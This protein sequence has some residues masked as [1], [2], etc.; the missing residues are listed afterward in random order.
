MDPKELR[1]LM[2]AYSEVYSPKENIEEGLRSAVKRLL[3][4]GKK[5]TEAPKPQSRGDQLRARYN[6]GPEGSDTSAKRK[7]LDRAK[8]NAERAQNQVDMGNASQSY[9]SNA[10]DAHNKYLKAGYSKYGADTPY[11]GRGSKARKRAAALNAEDFEFIVNAL[12]EEGYDLSSYTWDEMYDIC[13]DENR[14][15]SRMEK[16]PSAPAKVGKATHSTKD[17]VPSKEPTPEEK[18]KARKA[19]GLGEAVKGAS[20]HDTEMRKASSAERRAGDK[21]LSPAKGRDNANKMQRDIN[22]F[23]KLTKK[24]KNV[25]GLVSN[26]EVDLF[27]TVLEFLQVEGYAETLEEA[28]WLM[29]NVID[30]E[31]IAII[32]DEAEGSYG[33]TPKATAAYGA[34]ANRR[35]NTPASEYPKRGAKKVAVQ[36]AERHMSRSENPDAGNRGKQSTKPHWTSGSR[37]GMTPKDR[38]WRRGADEYGHS[39]YDGEGGGGSLPKGKKLERQRKTGVSEAQEARNNPEKYEAGQQKKSAPVR[40]ERTPMPPRGDKRREDFEKWYAANGPR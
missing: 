17:L 27:D 32:L 3:G 9:A 24:N 14:M 34:L 31:A 22:Y 11:Q 28:E 10:K 30:E 37:K 38:N 23:D 13:L 2:E 25:V 35:R 16:M 39:G 20:R 15:A 40:G 21:P 36:S 4:G 7:I 29:A 6:V 8:G 33:Q 18:A 1:G 26:E 5:E 12:I 19:L